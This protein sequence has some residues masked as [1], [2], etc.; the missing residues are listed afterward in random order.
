[1]VNLLQA[2]CVPWLNDVAAWLCE[3]FLS[4]FAPGEKSRDAPGDP[5][6]IANF[7]KL[8]SDF[9]SCVCRLFSTRGT[10]ATRK[11]FE[12]RENVACMTR[13]PS[14]WL[15]T[16]WPTC[17]RW[18]TC[19]G[20]RPVF[21]LIYENQNWNRPSIFSAI[22]WPGRDLQGRDQEWL[23]LKTKY[24]SGGFLR[25]WREESLK[26]SEFKKMCFCNQKT[27]NNQLVAKIS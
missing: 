6:C 17:P 18:S 24:W 25:R 10:Q 23:E 12:Q 26:I 9:Q 2:V 14:S 13:S 20:I 5:Q 8:C 21:V 7:R 22:W 16:S 27:T 19:S 11:C 15:K 3:A 1:M 4:G